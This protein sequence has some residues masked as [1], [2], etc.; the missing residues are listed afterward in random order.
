MN[1]FSHLLLLHFFVLPGI[2]IA[3]L[4]FSSLLLNFVF[5]TYPQTNDLLVAGFGNGKIHHFEGFPPG[6]DI[7]VVITNIVN[8]V[9]IIGETFLSCSNVQKTK[10]NNNNNKDSTT[11]AGASSSRK[12]VPGVETPVDFYTLVTD[13]ENEI[14]DLLNNGDGA[15]LQR[16]ESTIFVELDIT[17]SNPSYTDVVLVGDRHDELYAINLNAILSAFTRAV[18]KYERTLTDSKKKSVIE[19]SLDE[20]SSLIQILLSVCEGG[21]LF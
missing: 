21:C 11:S 7:N 13:V 17:F 14:I 8:Q 20:I 2:V 12:P 4:L 9:K 6:V 19:N 10:Q 15:A 18:Y 16:L 5:L 3:A 1:F